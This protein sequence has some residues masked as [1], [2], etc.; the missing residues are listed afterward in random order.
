[1][2][3]TLVAQPKRVWGRK[4]LA[5]LG[6]LTVGALVGIALGFVYLQAAIIGLLIPPLTIFAVISLLIAAVVAMGWRW[7]PLLGALWSAFMLVGNSE[8]LAY[9]LARPQIFHEFAFSLVMLAVPL[10]GLV[11][12]IGA[13]IQNYRNPTDRRTPRL[14]G[15]GLT[16]IVALCLGAMLAAIP[17][18]GASTGVSPEALAAL[19]AVTSPGGLQFDRTELRAKVGE[20]VALRLANPSGE[21]H[22]FDIDAFNIHVPM[23]AGE[24]A[25][26]LF[27][28]TTAGTYT[29]YCGVPAHREVMVGKLIVE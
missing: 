16:T 10:I 26:A 6:R 15:Y 9:N 28:T 17:Q 12:G 24:N 21:A 3:T 20:T 19:P 25:L 2:E 11:A 4:S 8:D 22:S 29:F 5:A 27:K 7:T 1:M 23:P 18:V 13:T 14:L